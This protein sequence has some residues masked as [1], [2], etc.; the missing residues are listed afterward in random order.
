[1]KM[2]AMLLK[3]NDLKHKNGIQRTHVR[4]KRITN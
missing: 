4:D 2:N 1:M 3:N